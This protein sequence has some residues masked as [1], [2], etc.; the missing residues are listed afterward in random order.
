MD[1]V[2]GT[3]QDAC[4]QLHVSIN[5]DDNGVFFTSIENEYALMAR[6]TELILDE[7]TE[8]PRYKKADIYE[9][10]DDIRKM[11]N[12]QGFPGGIEEERIEH[13]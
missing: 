4:A 10:L 11:S 5:T 3:E 9:W 1:L 12:E 8:R 6:A 13:V 7:E 2:H